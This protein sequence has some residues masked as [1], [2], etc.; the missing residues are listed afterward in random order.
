MP[1]KIRCILMPTDFSEC[2]HEALDYA[3]F[4]AKTFRAEVHLLHVIH[5]PAHGINPKL[6]NP[7]KE[8]QKEETDKLNGLKEQIRHQ[9]QNVYLLCREGSPPMEILKAADQI[10]ADL[11]VM[12]T[13]GRTGLAHTL[14]GSVAERVVQKASCPVL[15]VRWKGPP[16]STLEGS[17][18]PISPPLPQFSV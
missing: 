18:I 3:V 7:I 17:L 9:C 14:M 4:I 12:G 1:D 5:F 16:K 2:S 10:P 13:H 8:I 15:T 6:F 11:I